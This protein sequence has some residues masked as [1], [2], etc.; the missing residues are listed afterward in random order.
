M[1]A[2]IDV[3]AGGPAEQGPGRAWPEEA[4][5][6]LS[7]RGKAIRAAKEPGTVESLF[8]FGGKRGISL[9]SLHPS[10]LRQERGNEEVGGR[11]SQ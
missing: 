7:W 1:A 2:T 4:P 11:G 6:V 3:W 10:H 5:W 9:A 8:L